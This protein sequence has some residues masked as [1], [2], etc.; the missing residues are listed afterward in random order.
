MSTESQSFAGR[1]QCLEYLISE[2]VITSTMCWIIL[3]SSIVL[4]NWS[5]ET[6]F[7]SC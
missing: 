3:G 6:L 2:A 5:Q 4:S 7:L 1:E